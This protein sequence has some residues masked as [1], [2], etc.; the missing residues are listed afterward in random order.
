M[1][2]PGTAPTV[3]LYSVAAV[4][5]AATTGLAAL[6]QDDTEDDPAGTDGNPSNDGGL[7]D[8]DDMSSAL[9]EGADFLLGVGGRILL[10]LLI[11]VIAHM[12]VR[13][14]IGR[15]AKQLIEPEATQRLSRLR[16]RAPST[17]GRSAVLADRATSRAHTLAQVLRSIATA[18]IWAIAF[19]MILGELGINLGPLIAGAGIAGVAL[20]FGAQ[21]L[22][23]DFLTGFF[24]LVEDQCGVGDIVDLGEAVGV[25]EA[26]SMRTTRVRDLNGTLWHVPN[27]Q[28]DRVANLSQEWSRAVLDVTVAYGTDLRFAQQIIKETADSLWH[29]PDWEENIVEEPEVWGVEAFGPDS[30]TIRLVLKTEPA[31]QWRIMREMRGRLWLALDQAHIEIPFPQRTVWLRQESS[32]ASD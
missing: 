30:I 24:M 18:I 19:M 25:V 28:I 3:L 5:L 15:F 4:L 11:A 16:R 7:F 26:V 21:S 14:A 9:D 12:V 23:K 13:R 2:R 20:G 8:F 27:G 32:D 31:E 22:V 17:L 29:D 10:I 1:P 6:I